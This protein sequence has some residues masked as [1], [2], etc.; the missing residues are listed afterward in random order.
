MCR[1]HFE[2]RYLSHRQ[3]RYKKVQQGSLSYETRHDIILIII[4][5]RNEL[6]NQKRNF[7]HVQIKKGSTNIISIYLVFDENVFS[8]TDITYQQLVLP[9]FFV[10]QIY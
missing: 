6:T 2:K 3:K 10:K 1:L 9:Y 5:T 8:F 4:K 7:I